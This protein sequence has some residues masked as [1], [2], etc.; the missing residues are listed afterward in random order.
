M[1]DTIGNVTGYAKWRLQKKLDELVSLK[2]ARKEEAKRLDKEIERLRS[3][4]YN[5][6]GVN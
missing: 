2:K 6:Q 1:N 4:L 3:Q 5:N